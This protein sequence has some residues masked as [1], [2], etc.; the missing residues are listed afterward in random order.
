MLKNAREL[1]KNDDFNQNS[2][3]QKKNLLSPNYSLSG[4]VVQRI[5]NIGKKERLDYDFLF[6]ITDIKTGLVIWDNIVSISKIK[7]EGIINKNDASYV[8]PTKNNRNKEKFQ[9]NS[10]FLKSKFLSSPNS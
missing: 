4:K 1:R 6:T 3:I 2:V 9:K 7:N 10:N 8:T 5:K